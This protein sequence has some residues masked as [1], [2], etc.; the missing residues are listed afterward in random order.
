MYTC[1]YMRLIKIFWIT[2]L[3]FLVCGVCFVL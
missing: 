1:D 2:S 3:P